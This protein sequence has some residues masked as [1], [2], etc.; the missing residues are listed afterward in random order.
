MW[1]PR[2]ERQLLMFYAVY[3]ADLNENPMP[4]SV[5]ELQEVAVGRLCAGQIAECVKRVKGRKGEVSQGA[6]R[7]EENGRGP[8]AHM[9]WLQAKGVIESANKRLQERGLIEARE[10]GTGQY[11]VTITLTGWDLGCKYNSWWDRTG[12]WFREYKDH[13]IWLIVSFAGGVLGALVV[14]WLS[15]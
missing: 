2:E 13:W 1:L 10:C 7:N 4:F 9:G 14:K 11:E 12:L 8:S 3:D 15:S 5:G 6:P